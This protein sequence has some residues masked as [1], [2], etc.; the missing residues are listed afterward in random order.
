[1]TNSSFSSAKIPWDRILG[2]N[3]SKLKGSDKLKVVKLL[4]TINCYYGC[5]DS[6]ANCLVSSPGC[7]TAR[8]IAGQIVR[9]VLLGRSEKTIKH[10]ILLRSKSMHPFKKYKIK[11]NLKQCLRNP[12]KTK[13]VI[14]SYSDFQCPYCTIILPILEKLTRK[15]KNISLCFKNFPTQTH[16]AGT[17]LSSMAAVAASFQ[18]KFWKMHNILYK[19]RKSQSE[20]EL[21]SY[22]KSIGL[23]MIKFRKEWKS[24]KIRKI[25]AHEKREG[26]KM[27]VKGTPTIF[28]N[29]KKYFGRKDMVNFK[30]RITE[31]LYLLD[32]R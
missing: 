11:P 10:A 22:A 1:M 25:V 2:G 5:S 23:N 24:R 27:K 8:L 13:I 7:F 3:V 31:E 18:G 17:I 19:H 9:M 30:D 6:V 12:N 32:K 15:N 28:I 29:G 16:G 20:K 21:I 4:K 14:T 26:L